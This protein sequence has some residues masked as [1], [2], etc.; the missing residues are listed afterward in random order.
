MNNQ[1]IRRVLRVVDTRGLVEEGDRFVPAPETG[2]PRRCA[3]CHRQHQVHVYVELSDGSQAVIGSSCIG[4]NEMG[5]RIRTLTWLE[6]RLAELR[7]RADRLEAEVATWEMTYAEVC[8]L[9]LPWITSVQIPCGEGRLF[10]LRMGDATV[11]SDEGG[12]ERRVR[13]LTDAWRSRRMQERGVFPF[14]PYNPGY[15]IEIAR[16]EAQ[17]AREYSLTAE[18]PAD[19]DRQQKPAPPTTK[20]EK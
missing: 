1:K 16:L 15:R 17:L 8:A 10:T 4:N 9:P 7:L 18:R 11:Y 14:R 20:E 3:C 13:C 5:E 12:T 19:D 2:I 6:K